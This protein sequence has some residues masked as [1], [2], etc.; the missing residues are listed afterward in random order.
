M[1]L[2]HAAPFKGGTGKTGG[3]NMYD[4]SITALVCISEQATNTL[5]QIRAGKKP[6]ILSL[7]GN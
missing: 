1:G 7:W 6:G 2:D 4:K 5:L 3:K